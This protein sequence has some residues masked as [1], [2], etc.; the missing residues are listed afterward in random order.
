MGLLALAGS[1]SG[2]GQGAEKALSTTQAAWSQQMLMDE[3][4]KLEQARD[5]RLFGQQKDLQESNQAFQ[6]GLEQQR[7]GAETVRDTQRELAADKRQAKSEVAAQHRAWE[8]EDFEAQQAE[9]KRQ[10]DLRAKV[11]EASIRSGEKA[12]DAK[13]ELSMLVDKAKKMA[14]VGL[15]DKV[16]EANRA[17]AADAQAP[18]RPGEAKGRSLDNDIKQIQV[19]NAKRLVELRQKY[20]D[21]KTLPE[22]RIL[23]EKEVRLLTGKDNTDNYIPVATSFDEMTGKPNGYQVFNKN[24]GTFVTPTTPSPIIKDRF[25]QGQQTDDQL[26]AEAKTEGQQI[27]EEQL[28][29]EEE[30]QKR[31]TAPLT[32]PGMISIQRPP[33]RGMA[34]RQGEVTIQ[35]R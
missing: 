24:T 11:A 12:E 33:Q 7:Q 1:I 18:E 20:S 5:A 21:P 34:R 31:A 26:A 8:R 25:A 27:T 17:H 13:R 22:E 32:Q 4:A 23:I 16:R 30:A 9:E 15:D 19:N 3:R 10:G 29:R 28:R 14:E 35:P 6:A 2:A